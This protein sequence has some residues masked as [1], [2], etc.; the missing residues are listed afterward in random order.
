MQVPWAREEMAQ[1]K[2]EDERLNQRLITVLT[3]LG[4]RPCVSIPAACGGLNETVA[5][6]RFFDNENVTPKRILEPHFQRTQ[7]RMGEH[8][9]VLLTQDTTELDFTRP[10]RQMLGAGPLEGSQRRGAYVHP[11]VAFTPDGVPLGSVDVEIWTRDDASE[12]LT[13]Q[14]KKRRKATTPI[15]DKESFRWLAGLRRSREIAQQLPNTRCVCTADSEADIYEL[16]TE[17]RGDVP[18]HWL[19]RAG[20]DRALHQQPASATVLANSSADALDAESVSETARHIRE[21]VALAP[22]LFTKEISV[23]GRE[24]KVECSSRS[25]AGTDRRRGGARPTRA[26]DRAPTPPSRVDRRRTAR[27]PRRCPTTPTPAAR[28]AGSA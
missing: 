27:P 10:Q 25:S 2:L 11:L 14:E 6:Y 20:Q 28:A 4:E 21:Q 26:R 8:A 7:Q 3:A 17:P 1:A 12:D 19:V 16:F 24:A 18:V 15:E 5:A 23:R 22:V 9:V 13:P